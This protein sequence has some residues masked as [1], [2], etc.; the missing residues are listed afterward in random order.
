MQKQKKLIQD[1]VF[2]F[3][4]LYSVMYDWEYSHIGKLNKNEEQIEIWVYL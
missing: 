3:V 1:K 2:R 4:H